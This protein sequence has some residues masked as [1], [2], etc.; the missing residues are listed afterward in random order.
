MRDQESVV[1]Y[2]EATVWVCLGDRKQPFSFGYTAG[3]KYLNVVVSVEDSII[4]S[5][6]M[7]HIYI[8]I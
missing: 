4:I 1:W 8:Y 7:V 5:V 3:L 6:H 2:V